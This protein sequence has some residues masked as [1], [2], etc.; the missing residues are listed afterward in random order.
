MAEYW[1]QPKAVQIAPHP[2]Y[3]LLITFD[4]GE[5]RV[6][7]VKPY[8]TTK[9]YDELK[10]PGLFNEVKISGAKIEWRPRLDIDLRVVYS[11]STPQ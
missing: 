2:D 11:E 1:K 6:F 3:Q 10:D 5:K 7:D 8:L 4:N 9:P